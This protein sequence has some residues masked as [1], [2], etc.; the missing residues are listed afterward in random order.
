MKSALLQ[1]WEGLGVV[2]TG[3]K[4]LGETDPVRES[5]CLFL[6]QEGYC[7]CVGIN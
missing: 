2:E 5:T 1:V 4:M 3:R 6:G 7:S